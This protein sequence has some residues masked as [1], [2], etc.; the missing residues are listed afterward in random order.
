MSIGRAQLRATLPLLVV[1]EREQEPRRESE[2]VTETTVAAAFVFETFIG[3][4]RSIGRKNVEGGVQFRLFE[5]SEL[6]NCR[7]RRLFRGARKSC[8]KYNAAACCS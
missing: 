4:S 3:A 2:S 5:H 8:L 1:A 7:L 6:R